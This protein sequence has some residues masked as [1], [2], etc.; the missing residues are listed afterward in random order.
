M[1]DTDQAY[2]T[3]NVEAARALIARA[4]A[5]SRDLTDT[6][7]AEHEELVKRAE[8]IHDLITRRRTVESAVPPGVFTPQEPDVNV[9]DGP[10]RLGGAPNVALTRAQVEELHAGYLTRAVTS[11]TAPQTAVS[12]FQTMPAG[13]YP[14]LRDVFRVMNLIPVEAT[15]KTSITYYRG[16]TAADQADVVGEGGQKPLSDPVYTAVVEPVRK[17]AHYLLV[18]EEALTDLASFA[19]L[20]EAEALVGLV[21]KESQQILSGTG[22]AVPATGGTQFTGL[23]NTSGILTYT[24]GAAEPRFDS[25]LTGVTNLANG[26]A[27]AE[28]KQIIMHPTDYKTM[29][30]SRTAGSGEFLVNDMVGMLPTIYRTTRIPAG[31]ALVADLAAA[32]RIYMRL[33]PTVK[34]DPYSAS[35]TNQVKVIVEERFA[36]T[37]PRPTALLKVTFVGT[38]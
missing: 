18:S 19:D 24:P 37:V 28:A 38:S 34:V 17:L 22:A 21:N 35:T 4:E 1:T 2:L 27:F 7:A 32:A 23:L 31:T 26:S 15:D 16:T 33:T 5:E 12:D 8:T 29:L 9:F 30:L 13:T 11:A 25:L 36:L 14:I 6:E 10:A 3:R 20:L